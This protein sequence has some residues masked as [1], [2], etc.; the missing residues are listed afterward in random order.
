M[1]RRSTFSRKD[2]LQSLVR[3]F[4]NT[5]RPWPSDTASV[6]LWALQNNK[7]RVPATDNVKYLARELSRALRDETFVDP[8]G[9]TV[10]KNHSYREPIQEPDGTWTQ[11]VL[12]V[13]FGEANQDQMHA[14]L[15]LRRE[16]ILGDCRQLKTDMDS[17]NDNSEESKQ[18]IQMTF[19]FTMDLAE[20]DEPTTYDDSDPDEGTDD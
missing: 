12:W 17:F 4:R 8:Q 10:R 16:Q 1:P 14:S 15:Q 20:L 7:W 2:A 9:R 19:D 18:P 13:E 11:R 6:A 5:G 3:E